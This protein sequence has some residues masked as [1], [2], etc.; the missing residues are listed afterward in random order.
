MNA[1]KMKQLRGKF[2]SLLYK[3][4][5][6]TL[7]P[8]YAQA[9]AL[10]QERAF[11]EKLSEEDYIKRFREVHQGSA[12]SS[13]QNGVKRQS[14]DKNTF[15]THLK[16]YTRQ[17][18]EVLRIANTFPM[19]YP[20]IQKYRDHIT[21]AIMTARIASSR[22]ASEL[23]R[24]YEQAK[25]LHNMCV[26]S[27]TIAKMKKHHAAL[28]KKYMYRQERADILRH[29]R[30][31]ILRH[32]RVALHGRIKEAL[33]IRQVIIEKVEKSSKYPQVIKDRFGSIRRK[34]EQIV[35]FFE[36]STS[37]IEAVRKCDE[38]LV[39]TIK[40]WRQLTKQTQSRQSQGH[41]TNG[42]SKVKEFGVLLKT[43]QVILF[44]AEVVENIYE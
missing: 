10:K 17:L 44:F 12:A 33:K 40:Q 42:S 8:Q 14:I 4:L 38:Y 6:T 31:D 5:L 13:S 43:L 1:F 9:M 21:S 35:Q 30:A 27:S 7:E 25:K 41:L 32:E 18:E 11:F 29:E 15:I 24:D 34:V 16:K 23:Q 20:K 3:L 37:N 36:R 22:S 19:E 28:K 26:D 2:Q 39:K